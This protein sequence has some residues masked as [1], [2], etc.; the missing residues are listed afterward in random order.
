MKRSL[1]LL[2]AKHPLVCNCLLKN[3]TC[4]YARTSL[5]ILERYRDGIK[6]LYVSLLTV[7]IVLGRLCYTTWKTMPFSVITFTIRSWMLQH[8]WLGHL[9]CNHGHLLPEGRLM[10]PLLAKLRSAR[11]WMGSSL[12]TPVLSPLHVYGQVVTDSTWPP[13]EMGHKHYKNLLSW[14]TWLSMCWS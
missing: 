1:Y 12:P 13:T 6:V 2:E 7:K 11:G 4:P 10:W 8:L 9:L 14:P 5:R 3:R